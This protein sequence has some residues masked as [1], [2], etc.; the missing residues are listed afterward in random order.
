M[1]RVRALLLDGN[2]PKQLWAECVCHVTTLVNMTPSST[3]NG[4]TP[5]ELWYNRKPS[6]DY[7]KVF[8]CSAYAHITEQYRDKPDA[9]ARLCMYL[10]LPEHKKG[11]RLMA[12]NT[13]AIVYSRDVTFRED[14]FPR[15]QTLTN[16]EQ[17]SQMQQSS[18]VQTNL[19]APRPATTSSAALPVLFPLREAIKRTHY[20]FCGE[21]ISDPPSSPTTKKPHLDTVDMNVAL[22]SEEDLQEQKQRRSLLYTLLAIRQ[23]GIQVPHG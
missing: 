15:L 4:R 20:T 13:H 23:I 8:G 5:Y 16:T 14:E 10:G 9:R 1:E 21:T 3:T 19:L 6:M 12:V 22:N 18:T 2:L 11:Y 7:I 17:S